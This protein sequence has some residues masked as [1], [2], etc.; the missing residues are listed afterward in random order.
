[1]EL[2]RLARGVLAVAAAGALVPVG[3]AGTA[4]AGTA[5]AAGAAPKPPGTIETIAGGP[6]GPGPAAN[7]SVS[8]CGVRFAGGGLYIG[9]NQWDWDLATDGWLNQNFTTPAVYRVNLRDGRL[10]TVAG[11]GTS[12][13]GVPA[14][15]GLATATVVSAC[16]EAMDSAGNLLIAGQNA[17]YQPVRVLA[18][19]TGTYY[20]R[21]MTAGHVYTLAGSWGIAGSVG[22][23]EPGK[24][25]NLVIAGA[26]APP[27]IEPGA[28]G[29]EVDAQIAVL[30]EHTGTFYGLAM[31][32][33]RV[34]QIAGTPAGGA[35]ADGIRA[36]G[37]DL[38]YALGTVRTDSSGNLIFADI[39]APFGA[40]A[41][42]A[43]PAAVRVIA[44]KTGVYYGQHM[45]AG[46]L[47]TIAG[48]GTETA[49]GVPG[50]SAA[51]TDAA[52]V[53]LDGGG[54]V[55]IADS[56]LYY[57]IRSVSR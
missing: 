57:R 19:R 42:P 18:A 51:L 56:S 8:P 20:R 55:L 54:N 4:A 11:I 30:A 41:S 21:P 40:Q 47:Y 22:A 48:G 32:A 24:A 52:A 36:T 17:N 10:T 26:G 53:S 23:V 33:G 49:D 34:Y 9:S 28:P 27:P 25:G 15:G 3:L 29:G 39:G 1:M 12:E 14:D 46:Y 31:S 35:V 2:I 13:G 50:T 43:P 16:N 37:A 6:G 5:A 7:V 44:D 38:G 45:R